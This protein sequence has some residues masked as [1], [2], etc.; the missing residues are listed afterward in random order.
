M[1][2]RHSADGKIAVLIVYVDNII[3]TG[4]DIIEMKQLKKHQT[5]EFEI[6]DLGSLK[7]FFDMEVARSRKSVVVSQRKYMMDLLK[8]TGMSGCRPVETPFDPNQN[9]KTIREGQ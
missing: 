6:K 9:L 4:D 5:S 3:L 7:Y 2:T 8:E 1:F